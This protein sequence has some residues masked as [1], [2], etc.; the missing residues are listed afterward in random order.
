M[1]PKIVRFKTEGGHTVG[2]RDSTDARH[3]EEAEAIALIR[4]VDQACPSVLAATMRY[5]KVALRWVGGDS[6]PARRPT[7][8]SI[9]KPIVTIDGDDR[10]G[11]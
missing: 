10:P 9:G 6:T 1:T 2:A 3:P 11:A 8:K 5:L 7:A 4:R